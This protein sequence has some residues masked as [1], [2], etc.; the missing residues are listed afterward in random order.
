MA[1]IKEFQKKFESDNAFAEGL[2]SASDEKE[3]LQKIKD[4]GFDVTSEELADY[5]NDEEG[6]LDDDALEAVAGGTAAKPILKGPIKCII[7]K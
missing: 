3:L 2:Q 1:G 7:Q 5:F 6:E 4:A